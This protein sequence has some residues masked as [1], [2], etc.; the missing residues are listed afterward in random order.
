VYYKKN[1]SKKNLSLKCENVFLTAGVFDNALIL[2]KSN[3]FYEKKLKVLDSNKYYFLALRSKYSSIKSE[4]NLGSLSESFFQFDTS[5]GTIHSQLYPSTK[6]LTTL[7]GKFGFIKILAGFF[8]IGMIYLPSALSNEIEA[9]LSDDGQLYLKTSK[10]NFVLRFF[11]LIKLIYK[12]WLNLIP[13]GLFIIPYLKSCPA[14]N[15]Q[16]SGSFLYN[17]KL[18]PK[19]LYLADTSG[20]CYIP[21]TPT[22]AL[23]MAHAMHIG[24]HHE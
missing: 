1:S 20:L 16:H 14:G 22:T 10:R 13:H 15:S 4:D 23:A 5:Y 12:T 24:D 8:S 21:G 3:F 18:I 11:Y 9:Q 19:G 2:L 17:K 7:L 6:L